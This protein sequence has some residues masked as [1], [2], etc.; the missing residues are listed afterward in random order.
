[1]KPVLEELTDADIP[2]DGAGE[3]TP[4]WRAAATSD[5][6][7]PPRRNRGTNPMPE[8]E[9]TTVPVATL[10]LTSM[11]ELLAEVDE[12]AD[13]VV[14]GLIATAS[15]NVL[16]AK[17]KVGKSTLA[18]QLA[19]CVTRAEDFLGRRCA[20]PPGTVWYVALEGRRRDIR[21]HFRQ[22]GATAADPLWVLVDQ[23]PKNIVAAVQTRALAERPDLII[24]DTMQRFL[25]AKSTDD[26]AEMTLLFDPVLEIARKSGAAVLLIT[27]SSKAEKS[28]MDAILGSTAIAGSVD[29][30]I[31]LTRS[32][33]YRTIETIQRTG[34]DMD[35]TLLVLDETTGRLQLGGSRAIA[36]QGLVTEQLHAALVDAGEPLTQPELFERVEARRTVKLAA[37]K[38]LLSGNHGNYKAN[39]LGAGTRK[40]P[41]RYEPLREVSSSVVPLK[42]GNHFFSPP[43]SAGIPNEQAERSSSQVPT[44]E[45]AT[46]SGS[47]NPELAS[48][49]SRDD[50]HGS[51]Y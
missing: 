25:R 5:R 27:H 51:R 9:G 46:E 41:Y 6:D 13:Y 14:E 45:A 24:I 32:A 12:E 21:A 35:E 29:T 42:G 34:A 15:V 39:R 1:M 40:E 10:P 44:Q 11:G 37:L 33:R 31:L 4:E 17:P 47:G 48:P 22:L 43:L 36:D 8:T 26:Y 23:A 2:F 7:A 20:A 3:A 30:A 19:L 28:G 50:G 38:V 16:S 18:R 49:G